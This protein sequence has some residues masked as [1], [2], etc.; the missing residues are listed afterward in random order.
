[1]NFNQEQ[2]KIIDSVFGAY[3]VCAPVG[4]GKTTVLAQR[5]L[6]A[7]KQ[8]IKPEEILC[9]TFTNK[10]AA[11]M[12]S[13][14][15][16]KIIQ[17]E[18][19]NALTVKT[20][21]GFCA[22]IV[23][24]EAKELGLNTDFTIIDEEEQMQIFENILEE[25]P[26][27]K[28]VRNDKLFDKISRS[29]LTEMENVI[30]CK[31][32]QIS[33][34]KIEEQIKDRYFKKLTDLNVLDFNELV[35][36]TLRILYLEE[37]LKKKWVGRYKFIQ[38][39]EFQ[40]T[41]LSEYLV[42]KEL[43]K[44]HKNITFI[45]DLDQTIYSW[46]GSNPLFIAKI[47]KSH[48]AP[49]IEYD[50]TENYRFNPYLLSAVK[51]FLS[52]F[53]NS[54]TK[55]LTT[56]NSG[57]REKCITMFGGF[58]FKEE[59][60]FV[61]NELKR[62][63]AEEPSTT[64][65]VLS[66][67]HSLIRESVINFEEKNEPFITVDKFRF[68]RR[69]E[70]KDLLAC[71]KILFNKFDTESAARMTLRP[72]KI[73]T[74]PAFKK[75]ISEIEFTGLRVCDFFS[76]VNFGR[77]EPFE[78]LVQ[79]VD[80]GRVIV[81]DT[82]TTGTNPMTDEIVQI[83]AQE[84]VGG[85]SGDKRH[86]YL[87]NSVPVGLSE[88]IHGLSD[89]FLKEKGEDPKIVLTEIISFIGKDAI[90]G[91]NVYFDFKMIVENCRRL[92]IKQNIKEFYDTLD[93]SRRFIKSENYKLST[94]S[95]LLNFSSATHSADDDV[96]ATIDLFLYLVKQ[97]K[98]HTKEREKF[99]KEYGSKFLSLALK[100]ENWRKVIRDFRPDKAVEFIFEDSGLKKYY[101]EDDK[102]KEKAKNIQ[103]LLNFLVHYD[104]KEKEAEISLQEMVSR[105]ALAK[106]LDFLGLES[107][108]TPIITIHQAK[109]LEFDYIFIIGMNEFKFPAYKSDLEE[110]KRLFYVAL[111][112][113]KK[114]IYLSYS[115][116]NMTSF[117][118]RPQTRSR[119]IDS[120][121][122]KYLEYL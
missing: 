27:L 118:S 26:E 36:Y 7:L 59:I 78:K 97:L 54:Y 101:Y 34:T 19:I 31:T 104:D 61:I 32:S 42:V 79:A 73:M 6:S 98:K 38:V 85:K 72:E 115:N 4:T 5:V 81:L 116:N 56:S 122:Q 44:V 20:F 113:A 25:Y 100:I 120:L 28:E 83:F 58:D 108:K 47:F 33:L 70:I 37:N 14:I 93:L 24:S 105:F 119:F 52:S 62:L 90:V 11:E 64:V 112:R 46:R 55:E 102:E 29:R 107:G 9:L 111:T 51:S 71:V 88:N 22:N 39:D 94:L 86:F 109:G 49:V 75:M 103:M 10:A 23:K 50:L 87:K 95:K 2:Q 82:E 18:I 63:R 106:N 60:S 21:H 91:H 15:K 68:F 41:H 48:F 92:D 84:I 1:M 8:G 69:Q 99:F 67:G 3:L 74:A 30:G 17:T 65:A 40:D 89:E 117:G 35:V 12:V 96:A 121:E 16:T 76:F 77:S 66:R 80:K 43:A 53:E 110:E 45:G 13:R 114:H 57:G